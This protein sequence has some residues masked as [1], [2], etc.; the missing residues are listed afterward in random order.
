MTS[1]IVKIS[2]NCRKIK[3]QNLSIL[4]YYSSICATHTCL[5]CD[6]LFET[7]FLLT[8]CKNLC[9]SSLSFNFQDFPPRDVGTIVCA[10]IATKLSDNSALS[11]VTLRIT[12][13]RCLRSCSLELSTS[14]HSRPVFI[15]ILFLQPCQD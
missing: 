15:T 14:S 6:K 10:L 7:A 3:L 1:Q 12:Q 11:T 2:G 9:L 5:R 8:C 13:F 4:R